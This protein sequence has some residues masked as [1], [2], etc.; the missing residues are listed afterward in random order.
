MKCSPLEGGEKSIQY[1][2]SCYRIIYSDVFKWTWSYFRA[3]KEYV[4]VHQQLFQLINEE[5]EVKW[6]C[7]HFAIPNELLDLGS[8][9]QWRLASQLGRQIGIVCYVMEV[10]KY[11]LW[12]IIAAQL[13]LHL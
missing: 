5:G 9:Q 8:N 6:K 4:I 12:D 13:N 1:F 3:T 7:H 11:C 10:H 2:E